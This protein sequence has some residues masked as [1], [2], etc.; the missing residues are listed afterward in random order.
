M[1]WAVLELFSR[2][3]MW[4]C[5]VMG[6]AQAAPIDIGDELITESGYIRE[7]WRILAGPGAR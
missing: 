3:T 1:N 6:A 5:L 2:V 4:I 7:L